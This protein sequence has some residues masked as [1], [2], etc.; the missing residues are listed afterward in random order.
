[1]SLDHRTCLALVGPDHAA[2][3]RRRPLQPSAFAVALALA[4][5]PAVAL[6]LGGI[7]VGVGVGI[8]RDGIDVGADVGIG[9]L[10][11]D[12]DVGIGGGGVGVGVS[13]GGTGGA[14]GGTG[15]TGSTG[16]TGGTGGGTGGT[17]GG[18]VGTGGGAV[19]R[20]RGGSSQGSIAPLSASARLPCAGGGNATAFNGFV[21]RSM[22]GEALG[23]VNDTTIEA[24]QRIRSV[25]MMSTGKVCYA[26]NGGTFQV[27]GKEVWVNVDSGK[28]R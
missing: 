20:T 7:S 18:T 15:G 17:G 24:D 3:L 16:G 6:E 19:A 5:Q 22:D 25:K 2:I 26:I 4:A 27:S 8:D 10:G 9:G 14:A 12:A 13:V 21:V 11:V 23:W 28:F 1:M